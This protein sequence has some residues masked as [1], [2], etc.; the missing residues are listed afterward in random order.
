MARYTYKLRNLF[1]SY[2][3]TQ[4]LALQIK[5]NINLTYKFLWMEN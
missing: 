2:F 1:G 3:K 5:L 4:L